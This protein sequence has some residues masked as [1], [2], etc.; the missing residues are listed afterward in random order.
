MSEEDILIQISYQRNRSIDFC[1]ELRTQ[2]Q[3]DKNL[4]MNIKKDK[5]AI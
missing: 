4:L 3:E 5:E 2:L 1:R